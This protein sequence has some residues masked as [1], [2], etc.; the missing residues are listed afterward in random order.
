[1]PLVR[2]TTLP[3]NLTF[4]L[5]DNNGNRGF[6]SFNLP[7]DLT[8]AE[9]ETYVADLEAGLAAVSDARI[10]RAQVTVVFTQPDTYVYEAPDSSEVERKLVLV[11]NDATG[12][13]DFRAEVPSP[14]FTLETDG[15]DDIDIADPNVQLL[16]ASVISGPLGPGNGAITF[17]GRDIVR[18]EK[19]YVSHRTRRR[20]R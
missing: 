8:V 6:V 19:A 14:K 20:K 1:M 3:L 4:T 12:F 9:A 13:Y 18:I 11:F 16:A 15:T 2:D 17:A 7:N 5:S 10:E